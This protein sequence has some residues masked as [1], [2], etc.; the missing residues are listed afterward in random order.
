MLYPNNIGN[1]INILNSY[2]DKPIKHKHII[3]EN[4]IA[5]IKTCVYDG[6]K[7]KE[8]KSNYEFSHKIE[9]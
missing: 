7:I 4:I 6:M 5:D 1:K 2:N 9:Y 3:N 8:N